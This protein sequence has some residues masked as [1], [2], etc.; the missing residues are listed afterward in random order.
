M[1][2]SLAGKKNL[3]NNSRDDSIDKVF[4]ALC[5]CNRR[6]ILKTLSRRESSAGELAIVLKISLPGTM[7]HLGIL[8]SANLIT[9]EKNGRIRSCTFS[10]KGFN[11][12]IRYIEEYKEFWNEKFDNIERLLLEEK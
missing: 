3:R 8:E 11:T 6:M 9:L 7:K 2:I 1:N 4:F 5:D 12:A 10:P